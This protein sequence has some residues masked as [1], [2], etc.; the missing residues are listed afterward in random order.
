M[1][2]R[3]AMRRLSLAVALALPLGGC[4]EVASEANFD[5]SGSMTARVEF[6]VAPELAAIMSDP[7][8]NKDT[9]DSGNLFRDCEKPVAAKDLPPGATSM[10]GKL[11]QRDGL[12]TCTLTIVMPDPV[13]AAEQAKAKGETKGG[14]FSLER[15]SDGYRLRGTL[16]ITDALGSADPNAAE[17]VRAMSALAGAMFAGRS[18]SVTL[19]GARIEN[20]NGQVSSDATRVTWKW[21]IATL[22]SGAG[23]PLKIE[24]DVIYADGF[25][26]RWK[27]RILG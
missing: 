20:A 14:Q 21:P 9:K 26:A 25:F 23:G 16:S 11:G 4:L 5:T 3:L 17:Q 2:T 8:F 7:Q 15:I 10:T 6:A 13:A 19:V 27:K 18:V 12:Q 24:A 22:L 1:Q